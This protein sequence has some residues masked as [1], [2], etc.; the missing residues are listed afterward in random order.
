MARVTGLRERRGGRVAVE[1]DGGPWRELPADVVV[2]A[3]LRVGLDLDRPAL[4]ELRRALR[5][6]EALSAAARALRHRDLPS[7]AVDERLQRAGVASQAREEALGA[8]G[9]AGVVDDARYALSRASALA[10]RGLGNG[11]IRDDLE[12]RGLDPTHVEAGLAALEPEQARAAEIVAKRG[13]TP[14][15][16]RFLAARGFD[17]DAIEA[18]LPPAFAD[19]A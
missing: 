6:T 18:A 16:A 4:R 11:A 12:R 3:G 2:A 8:L 10:E 5:R 15:T 17:R 19:E 14:K 7:R 13:R 9:R 1:L